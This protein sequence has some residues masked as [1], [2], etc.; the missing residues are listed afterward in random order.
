MHNFYPEEDSVIPNTALWRNKNK[1]SDMQFLYH[2]CNAF[3]KSYGSKVFF[4]I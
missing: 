3:F 4:L 1:S 2:L